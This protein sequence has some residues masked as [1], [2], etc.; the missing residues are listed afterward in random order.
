MEI[1]G[2]L[3]ST[4]HLRCRNCGALFYRFAAQGQLWVDIEPTYM[5]DDSYLEQGLRAEEEPK[6]VPKSIWDRL[7]EEP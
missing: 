5:D 2:M 1:L 6:H 4:E 7:K 3:G